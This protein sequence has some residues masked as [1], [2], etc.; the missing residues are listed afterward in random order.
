M[1][2]NMKSK[3]HYLSFLLDARLLLLRQHGVKIHQIESDC[4]TF[5]HSLQCV[6]CRRNRKLESE[7]VGDHGTITEHPKN[8][9][10]ST[11]C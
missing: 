2:S 4:I 1:V 5:I 8:T 6:R 9:M 3:A 10:I 7:V 11:E